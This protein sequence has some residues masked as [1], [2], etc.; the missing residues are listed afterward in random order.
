M[1]AT[2]SLKG[3]FIASLAIVLSL[4]L[5]LGGLVTRRAAERQLLDS[6]SAT[7]ASQAAVFDAIVAADAEGLSRAATVLAHFDACLAPFAAGDHD[8]LLAAARPLF[9][10]MKATNAITHMYFIE[11]GGRVALRVHKPE[12]RGD[13]LSRATYLGARSSGRTSYG[14]ELGKN[15]FSLRSVRPIAYGG[16]Q[17]GYVEVAEEID[18]LFARAKEVTGDEIAVFLPSEYMRSVGAVDLTS[19]VGGFSIYEATAPELAATLG[20]RVRLEDGLTAPHTELVRLGDRVYAAGLAPLRDASGRA[21]GVVLFAK[22]LTA[23]HAAAL[24]DAWATT[25]LFALLLVGAG[26]VLFTA[27]RRSLAA[28]RAAVRISERISS[29]DL[30]VAIDAPGADEAGQLLRSMG[31]TVAR[32]REAVQHVRGASSAVATGAVQLSSGADVIS[33]AN[34]EQ[35]AAT[36]EVTASVG[37]M[38]ATLDRSADGARDAERLAVASAR[39]AEESSAAVASSVRAMREIAERTAIVEEIA[40]QTNLLALNAAIEAARAGDHGRGFAVVASEVRKLAERS[41]VAAVQIGE[42]TGTSVQVAERA[43]ALLDR[44]VPDIRVTAERVREIA[45]ATRE[46]ASGAAQINTSVQGLN[47]GVQRSAGSAEEIASTAQELRARSEDL[48][49]ALGFF[50]IGGDRLP[51]GRA[52]QPR[53]P[54]AS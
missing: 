5:L 28:L 20:A 31:E 8:A 17:I 48:E 40:Y 32:L 10:E 34:S 15:F 23:P 45:E 12:Q 39:S 52:A 44:L 30:E 42:I 4:A 7:L 26:V 9:E 43:S 47:E 53:L 14:I 22:N 54:R 49:A 18:H 21:A 16:E 25:G 36:E 27:L 37:D 50:K 51:A 41:R 11:P 13:V 46:V 24:R 19:E 2:Q 33:R 3:R 38:T 29:G 6:A 1:R 35:A